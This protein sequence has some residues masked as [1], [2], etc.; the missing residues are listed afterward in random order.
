MILGKQFEK[1]LVMAARLH[2]G[3]IRKGTDIPY[4]AHL[5]A[6]AALVLE[7]G[8]DEDMAI[9]AL[10]HDAVE[11]QGG[12]QTLDKIRAV[13]GIRV[14]R[15][16]EGCSDSVSLPKPPWRKRKEE[17]LEHLKDAERDILRVSLADKVHNA[18]SILT[19]LKI[20]GIHTMERFKGGTTGTLWYYQSLLKIYKNI[21][22]LALV[23]ELERV[24][25]EIEAI[26]LQDQ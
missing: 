21:G 13:F 26:I 18:R 19:D 17:Y 25:M 11:D 7:D 1:A 22:D 14:A 24:V 2:F 23:D 4:I 3:Q 10:L 20:S 5:L 16:V 8:G 9:A 15:I 6:V 12:S